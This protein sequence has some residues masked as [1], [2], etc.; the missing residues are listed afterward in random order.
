MMMDAKCRDVMTGLSSGLCA[1]STLT[2]SCL[3]ATCPV[4]AT[5]KLVS[6]EERCDK[7]DGSVYREQLESLENDEQDDG[8]EGSIWPSL[9]CA[10]LLAPKHTLTHI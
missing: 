5:Y 8:G 10:T 2:T 4:P 1:S 9:Y 7:G 6:E 3:S